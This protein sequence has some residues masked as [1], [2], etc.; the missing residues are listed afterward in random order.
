[1]PGM[2]GRAAPATPAAAPAA[3]GDRSV[4]AREVPLAPEAPREA[5]PRQAQKSRSA[6][7]LATRYEA[8]KASLLVGRGGWYSGRDKEA[9]VAAILSRTAPRRGA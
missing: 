2:P 7:A 1:M 4:A 8:L 9:F 5:A 6:D 3:D